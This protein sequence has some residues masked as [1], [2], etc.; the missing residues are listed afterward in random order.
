MVIRPHYNIIWGYVCCFYR[1]SLVVRLFFILRALGYINFVSSF[2][3]EAVESVL[4]IRIHSHYNFTPCIRFLRLQVY[5]VTNYI[6]YKWKKLAMNIVFWFKKNDNY[7]TYF[8]SWFFLT[9]RTFSL[10]IIMYN[11]VNLFNYIN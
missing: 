1:C 3:F 4:C 10:T 7:L 6:F 9:L 8:L 2:H 11:Y 5:F